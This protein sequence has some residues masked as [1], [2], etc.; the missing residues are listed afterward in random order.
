M[1]DRVL[2]GEKGSDYGLWI[3]K[4]TLDATSTNR[5][6]LIFDST[7]GRTGNVL[8]IMDINVSS[9]TS[10]TAYYNGDQSSIGYIPFAL[11][12]QID[13]TNVEGLTWTY[14][15]SF[16]GG[17]LQ[18]NI[19]ATYQ[20]LVSNASVSVSKYNNTSFS[21]LFRIIVFAIPADATTI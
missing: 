1:A 3:S 20:G 10:G 13:G 9:A 19:G 16:G 15:L 2:L 11:V 7:D 12:S 4:P 5:R 18:F 8:K 6:D 14:S 17:G 21:E